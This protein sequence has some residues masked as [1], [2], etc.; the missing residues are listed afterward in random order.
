M[1]LV[2]DA[3]ILFSLMKKDSVSSELFF[4]ID[5]EY[6]APDFLEVEFKNHLKECIIKSGLKEEDFQ[7]RLNQIKS[8]IKFIPLPNYIPFLKKSISLLPHPED[9]PYLAVALLLNVRIWSND[10]DLKKQTIVKVMNTKE[11]LEI[12]L[13]GKK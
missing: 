9:S 6:F 11:L 5:A 13:E 7:L 1:K 12:Y 8:K 4:L 10:K 2:I 3:N